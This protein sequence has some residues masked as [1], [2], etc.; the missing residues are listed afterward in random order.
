MAAS[1]TVVCPECSKEIQAPADFLG[2]K[3]RCKQCGHVFRAEPAPSRGVVAPAAG[4]KPPAANNVRPPVAPLAPPTRD[5]DE[6][7]GGDPYSVRTDVSEGAARCPECANEMETQ[8]AVIC[9][10][11]GYNTITR[12][13]HKLKKIHDITD[14]DKF[15]WLLPGFICAF[16]VLLLFVLD[17]LYC[18]LLQPD[19]DAPWIVEILGYRGTKM[20][21]SIS[22]VFAMFFLARFAFLRL[23]VHPVPPEVERH[24]SSGTPS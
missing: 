9:L 21:I 20:W 13:R 6:D 10:H 14:A 4:G 12:E 1:I 5:D 7:E 19:K 22:C 15:L 8:D 3:V 23:I 2:K 24:D 16:A 17:L 18:V 11:C